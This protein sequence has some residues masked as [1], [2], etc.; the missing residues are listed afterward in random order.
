MGAPGCATTMYNPMFC[1]YNTMMNKMKKLY[2]PASLLA[3]IFSVIIGTSFTS[4]TPSAEPG[5]GG[6][7][8]EEPEK[9]PL[10]EGVEAKS[11]GLFYD[12]GD[13]LAGLG[14]TRDGF[15]TTTVSSAGDWYL[16]SVGQQPGLGNVDY[17]PM[18]NWDLQLFPHEGEGFVGYNSKQGFVRFLVAAV[19]RDENR[20]VVGVGLLYLGAFSGSEEPVE[21]K[22]WSYDFPAEGGAQVAEL[23]GNKYSTYQVFNS[24]T[25]ATVQRTSSTYEFIQDRINIQVE[26]NPSTEPREA[27]ITLRTTSSKESSFKIYQE[28]S[29]E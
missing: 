25:W 11:I 17:I 24:T 15:L 19:A 20:E 2:M 14:F 22:E 7:A 8:G 13:N 26:P 1:N 18:S 29:A 4:C 27:I 21:L 5:S 10:P 16:S 23:K 3:L 12:S 9:K 28:G 6:S